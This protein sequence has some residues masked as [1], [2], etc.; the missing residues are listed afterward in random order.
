MCGTAG[1]PK[2]FPNEP[3]QLGRFAGRQA[4]PGGKYVGSIR[5]R[6]L[7]AVTDWFEELKR[8]L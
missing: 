2:G 1:Q 7:E 8:K 4:I 3:G 5:G 6:R